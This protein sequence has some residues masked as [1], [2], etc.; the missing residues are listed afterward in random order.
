MNLAKSDGDTFVTDGT[1]SGEAH[2]GGATGSYSAT[3]HGDVMAT[4][5]TVPQ[6]SAVVGEFN[7]HFSNGSVAG[8]FGANKK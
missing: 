8:G 7:A 3:F 2:G 1:A 4:D 6:P 5:G